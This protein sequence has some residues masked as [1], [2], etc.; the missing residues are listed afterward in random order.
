MLQRW[1]F[2]LYIGEDKFQSVSG[3]FLVDGFLREIIILE[4]Y[5]F[6]HRHGSWREIIILEDYSFVHRHGSWNMEAFDFE[7]SKY[8]FLAL[9]LQD[10]HDLCDL[11]NTESTALLLHNLTPS[12]ELQHKAVSYIFHPVDLLPTVT[13]TRQRTSCNL[14]G[15]IG[16]VLVLQVQNRSL[17]QYRS[18]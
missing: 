18:S 10:H 14:L 2:L 13:R 16:L 6:V 3:G 7:H 15:E 1:G 11:C 17:C 4:D 12:P 9:S 5:C 8:P